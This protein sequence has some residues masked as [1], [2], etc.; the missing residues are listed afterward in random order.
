MTSA[1]SKLP[2][3]VKREYQE[4]GPK[5]KILD[6]EI[7]SVSDYLAVFSSSYPT[8]TETLWFRGHGD[9]IWKPTP[10]ALR[11]RR[12]EDRERAL[13]LL[14]RFKRFAVMKLVGPPTAQEEFKWVQLAQHYGLPTRLLDWTENAAAALYF[15][16]LEPEQNGVVFCLNPQDL[17]REAYPK[18]P[19]IL[20]A[21]DQADAM[22]I[23]QYL[24]LSGECDPKNGLRTVA[25]N[26]IWNSERIMLQKGAFTLHGSRYFT[27]APSR[28]PYV[29]Y[30]PIP[31]KH[32]PTLL[33]ELDR[34][35][36]NEMSLFPEPEHLCSHLKIN[37]GLPR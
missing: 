1:I 10:S 15:A 14:S 13:S 20:D 11:Y 16:C 25:V 34:I 5:F 26:P 22:L 31:K 4:R 7:T 12:L 23:R 19:H 33:K 27:V 2:P 35:G 21:N 36:V 9:L 8:G 24:E 30:V 37:A 18:T 32:K 29:V 28:A 17:N 6:V 3:R